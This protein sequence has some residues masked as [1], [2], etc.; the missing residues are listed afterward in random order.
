MTKLRQVV[1][2]LGSSGNLGS[3]VMELNNNSEFDLIAVT[4]EKR[5]ENE[6]YI[7]N[8]GEI[9]HPKGVLPDLIVNLSNYYSPRESAEDIARM[10]KA[11]LGTARILSKYISKHQIGLISASTYL[12]YAPDSFHP[13]SRY[14]DFKQQAQMELFE[15]CSK[16]NTNFIDFVL[17]D[18]YGGRSRGKFL[19]QL[20]DSLED[21]SPLDATPGAQIL[22]LTHINDIAE[23]FLSQIK[24][25]LESGQSSQRIFELKSNYTKTLK[26]I[27]FDVQSYTGLKPSVNWGA[28]PY[29][30]HEVFEHWDNNLVVPKWWT[31]KIDFPTWVQGRQSGNPLRSA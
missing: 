13:W 19:D 30:D 7:D 15:E 2:L 8:R 27:V 5:G 20:L 3:K 28:I 29:R 17:Y 14:A 16:T 10:E 18:N 21:K 12:Q 25:T 11:I 1:A 31:P 26:D 23:G 9:S 4:R 6:F 24:R 22:N